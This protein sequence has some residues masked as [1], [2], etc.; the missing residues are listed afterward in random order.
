LRSDRDGAVAVD[1]GASGIRRSLS[2]EVDARYW[3][4]RVSVPLEGQ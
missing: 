2:R 1:F 4:N 3:H